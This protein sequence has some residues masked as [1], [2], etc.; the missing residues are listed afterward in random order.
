MLSYFDTQKETALF[1]DASPIGINATL[2]QMDESGH[3]KPVNIAS[4]A[5]NET[6]QEYHQLER[7]ALGIQFGCYRF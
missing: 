5:L 7:E 1:T 3:Y 2:A 6:E 4:R